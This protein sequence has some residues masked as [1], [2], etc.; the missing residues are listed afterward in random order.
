M[1]KATAKANGQKVKQSESRAEAKPLT[2]KSDGSLLFTLTA[3]AVGLG[4]T[5]LEREAAAA[6]AE[7][8]TDLKSDLETGDFSASA[9]QAVDPSILG[10]IGVGENGG[11]NVS[12]AAADPGHIA[13]DAEG[14]HIASPDML[15]LMENAAPAPD[16][17]ETASAPSETQLADASASR[18]ASPQSTDT[19]P[20]AS[21][22][23]SGDSLH[24][25]H[26][27]GI[28][29]GIDLGAAAPITNNSS[30]PS[31]GAVGDL[32]GGDSGLVSGVIETVDGAL[33][34]VGGLVEGLLGGNGSGLVPELV[35][36]VGDTV[37]AVG[38]V[39]GGTVEAVGDLVDGL[40]GG[41]GSGLVPELVETVG[42]TVGTVGNVVG[43]T[44]EAVG[45]LVGGLLGGGDSDAAPELVKTV[46]NTVD[47]VGDTL[48]GAVGAVGDLAGDLLGSAGVAPE[49]TETVSN[50]LETTV[51]AA[52]GLVGGALGAVGGLLGGGDSEGSSDLAAN[53]TDAPP[54]EQPQPDLFDATL[55]ALQLTEALSGSLAPILGF[56]GLSSFE[57]PDHPELANSHGSLLHGLI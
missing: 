31:D 25:P 54:A 3:G 53:A 43:G 51:E 5:L 37:G 8:V 17:A 55:D 36:T 48:G 38:N 19:P 6:T 1:S 22:A 24:G 45:G 12:V 10:G 40:L 32:P 30:I 56:L 7:A 47:T 18:D 29:G 26:E 14:V 57:V 20:A 50:A 23:G 28:G 42:D 49:L 44:V 11:A 15:Q 39:V 35:E 33:G 4:I 21:S 2:V 41:E 52:T 46:S 16:G 9:G 34:T 13:I 27:T